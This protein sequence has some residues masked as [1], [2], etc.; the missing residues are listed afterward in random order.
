VPDF[1]PGNPVRFAFL[2]LHH[3]VIAVPAAKSVSFAA[4]PGC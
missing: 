3:P 1:I 2:G 4:L